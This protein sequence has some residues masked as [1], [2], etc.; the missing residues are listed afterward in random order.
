MRNS[1]VEPS[2]ANYSLNYEVSYETSNSVLAIK[3]VNEL[4]S[5]IEDPV[6]F[7]KQELKNI[8]SPFLDLPADFPRSSAASNRI[9]HVF[10]SLSDS[11]WD[12]LK[13]LNDQLET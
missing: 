9:N 7:W 4:E 13:Q 1:E 5:T 10:F 8:T 6:S 2:S 3:Q 11:C 12:A